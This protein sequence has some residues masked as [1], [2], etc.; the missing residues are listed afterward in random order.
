MNKLLAILTLLFL[1]A[2]T[3]NAQPDSL[4]IRDEVEF[5]CDSLRQ[6]RARGTKGHADAAF[7]IAQRLKS[8]GCKSVTASSSYSHSF[9]VSDSTDLGHNI[10]GLMDGNKHR[11]IIVASHY[12][13]LGMIDGQMYESAD[14]HASGIAM[15]M[16]LAQC[17]AEEKAKGRT[18]AG[19]LLFIAFDSYLDGRLG[20]QSLV[21]ALAAGKFK[22]PS[23]GR[24]I[25]LSDIEL[26]IDLD[27]IGSSLAP[28]HTGRPDYLMA[29]G[30]HSLRNPN[31]ANYLQQCNRKPGIELD[32]G[33]TYYGSK[34]FTEAFYN[35][36]DRKHFIR[37]G[38]PT[39]Y[40]TSGITDLTNKLT[41]T[42]ES[43][44]YEVMYRRLLLIFNFLEKMLSTC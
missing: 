16:Q 25:R 12:D 19:K 23:D 5:F 14:A 43:L 20:S 9:M 38:I 39:L 36:G 15:M 40:F 3:S 44:D 31:A 26:M 41:D 27:Q 35:L 18:Y 7:Y 30:G 1:F 11:Y 34:A 2:V 29:I 24:T 33:N 13:G 42:A 10:L 6:G 8:L 4:S 17:F 37:R 28:L 32:L 21:K 22:D